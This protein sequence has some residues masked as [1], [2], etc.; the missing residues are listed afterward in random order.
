MKN[1]NFHKNQ[2]IS[3]IRAKQKGKQGSQEDLKDT[4]NGKR[5]LSTFEGYICWLYVVETS[6]DYFYFGQQIMIQIKATRSKKK[7]HTNI[8]KKCVKN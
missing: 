6:F 3:E 8:W 5:L 2:N 7:L 4:E 1:I